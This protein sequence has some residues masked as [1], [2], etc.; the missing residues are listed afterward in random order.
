MSDHYTHLKWTKT[1]LF[2]NTAVMIPAVL[3]HLD[4]SA[5]AKPQNLMPLIVNL[6]LEFV[7]ISNS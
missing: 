3:L 5:A 4:T 6:G 7:C 1:A 2:Q